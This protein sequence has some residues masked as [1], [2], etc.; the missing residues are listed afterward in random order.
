[1]VSTLGIPQ[2]NAMIPDLEKSP[3]ERR[4]HRAVTSAPGG[5]LEGGV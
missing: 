5:F 1:M 2:V 4:L 3:A